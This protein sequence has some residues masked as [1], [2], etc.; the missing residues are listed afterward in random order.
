MKGYREWEKKA[1]KLKAKED[2]QK[3]K[4]AKMA[5]QKGPVAA[6]S[7]AGATLEFE[8]EMFDAP[9]ITPQ[10]TLDEVGRA[11]GNIPP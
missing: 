11:V 4:D 2:K 8:E 5:G 1:K 3:K 7:A 10:K 9:P 6:A